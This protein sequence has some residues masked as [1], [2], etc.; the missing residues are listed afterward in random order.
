M[1]GEKKHKTQTPK[2]HNRRLIKDQDLVP[3][4]NF[5]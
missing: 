1:G 2:V 3:V 5:I 4:S